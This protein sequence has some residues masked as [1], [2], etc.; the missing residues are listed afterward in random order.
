MKLKRF[1]Q[2]SESFF[3]RFTLAGDIDF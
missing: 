1:H 3:F 2:I